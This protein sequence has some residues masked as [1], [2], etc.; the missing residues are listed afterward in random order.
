MGYLKMVVE[1]KRQ[2]R[3]NNTM[4]GIDFDRAPM[5][6]TQARSHIEKQNP[7]SYAYK[8]LNTGQGSQVWLLN[9]PNPRHP[10][11]QGFM[12]ITVKDDDRAMH[13]ECLAELVSLGMLTRT[14]YTTPV[15]DTD[16]QIV[17]HD[18]WDYTDYGKDFAAFVEQPA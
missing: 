17:Y 11:I 18:I 14:R 1:P 5:Q 7:L 3:V 12:A 16:P 9:K 2:E 4:D 10:S 8:D 15:S 13:E 6:V